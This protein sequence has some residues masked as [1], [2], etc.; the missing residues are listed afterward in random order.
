MRISFQFS[1]R[2]RMHQPSEPVSPLDL[3]IGTPGCLALVEAKVKR[4]RGNQ[5]TKGNPRPRKQKR[6]ADADSLAFAAMMASV[7]V[8]HTTTG[9]TTAAP[10]RDIFA[11]GYSESILTFCT[12]QAPKTSAFEHYVIVQS[13][14]LR[15]KFIIDESAV[16]GLC[17]AMEQAGGDHSLQICTLG[18]TTPVKLAIETHLRSSSGNEGVYAYVKNAVVA[19]RGLLPFASFDR[20]LVERFMDNHNVADDARFGSLRFVIPNVAMLPKLMAKFAERMRGKLQD[21]SVYGAHSIHGAP[22]NPTFARGLITC[23][24]CVDVAFFVGCGACHGRRFVGGRGM[25]EPW[26]ISDVDGCIQPST[27]VP[28]AEWMRSSFPLPLIGSAAIVTELVKVRPAAS[29]RKVK[30]VTNVTTSAAVA[31]SS[32][33]VAWAHIPRLDALPCTEGVREAL[34]AAFRAALTRSHPSIPDVTIGEVRRCSSGSTQGGAG[35]FSIYAPLTGSWSNLC[36]DAKAT[37]RKH[38]GHAGV[39]YIVFTSHKVKSKLQAWCCL[40]ARYPCAIWRANIDS[41]SCD[42]LQ[43]ALGCKAPVAAL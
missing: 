25:W 39:S 21:S 42:I 5:D 10:V 12:T 19:M 24:D 33:L 28:R 37:S 27:V 32:R 41:A 23:A 26:L 13:P 16:G 14:Q 40:S 20:V 43:T 6:V 18:E 31:A 36:L 9:S 4:Q 38:H 7:D 15:H 29:S 30:S 3:E 2:S 34:Q 11:P 1:Y 35:S 22:F 8:T 17:A